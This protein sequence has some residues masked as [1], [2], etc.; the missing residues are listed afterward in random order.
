MGDY[1]RKPLG[2][3]YFPLE[4]VPTPTAWVAAKNN[5]I[6]HRQHTDGGHFA[7]LEKPEALLE[8]IEAFIVR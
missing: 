4:I 5:L 3:S 2:Y 8:D 6:W 1:L 7:A